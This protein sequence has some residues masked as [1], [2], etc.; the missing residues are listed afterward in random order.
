MRKSTI[1]IGIAA[2]LSTQAFVTTTSA[3]AA[4]KAKPQRASGPTNTQPHFKYPNRNAPTGS[5]VL[6]D[7]SG[8]AENG[9]PAQDFSSTYDAYDAQGADDFVVTDAAGWNVSAFNFQVTF[10]AGGIPTPPPAGIVYNVTV[11]ADG[12]GLPGAAEC[13]YTGVPGVLDGTFTSLS[14]ALTPICSLTQGTHWVS[15][16]AS[17]D[18]PPQSFW[19]NQS[20]TTLGNEGAWQ[21]PGDGFGTGCTAWTSISSCGGSS[22]VGGG[23]PNYLFQVVGAVG[24]GGGDCGAGDLCLVTTVGTDTTPGAC[25][26][27]D[28]IDVS[29]GD[30]LNY[31]YV[32]TNNT[33][34][35]LDYHTLSDNINGTI[36]SLLNQPVPDGGTFQYN[37]IDT[38]SVTE[39]TNSSWTGQDVPPGYAPEVTGGGGGNDRIFCDGF[40]GTACPDLPGGGF[41]DITTT[42]TPL[43][44]GDDSSADVTMPFSFNFYGTTANTLSVSNNGAAVFN[45]PGSAVP[46]TNVSLPATSLA[47][48]TL[49]PLWDD[50]DSESG[51]VFTDTRGTAP[52]RQ[53][54][55]EWFNRVHF[56]GA[57]NT[58]G[59]TFE[60]ILNENGTIQF[61]YLDVDYTA[62]ANASGDPDDCTGGICATIGLQNDETLFNQFSAFEASITDNSGILW[63]P[64]SP[65][66]FTGTDSATVNVGAPEIDVQPPSLSGTVPEGGSNSI[67]FSIDNTGNRDLNWSL[68]E[69]GPADFH[70]PPPG[71]RF[72]MPLGDPALATNVR[73]PA[74]GNRGNRKPGAA[75]HAVFGPGTVP[76]FASDAYNDQFIRFDALNPGTVTTVSS[77]NGTAY[78]LDFIDADFSKAYGIDKFGSTANAFSTIDTATGAVTNIGTSNPSADAGG[79]TGFKYDSTTG[80]AYASGTSCG[81]SSHLYTIDITTGASTLVGE[82]TGM[83]CAITIAISPDGD[84]YGIDIVNDALFAIDK[85]NANATLIGSIGFNANYGQDADFDDATGILYYAAFNADTFTDEIRTV[86]LTSGATTLVGQIGAGFAQIVGLA[87]ET[88]GGPCA[89]PQDLPWLS[90][91]PLAGTTPPAG[92]SPVTASIDG[93]ANVEGDTLAGT[94]CVSSNDP[95]E[96]NVEV[97]I[98]VTVG[99]AGGGGNIVDSGV[100]NVTV[101]ADFTGLYINWLTGATCTSADPSCT[102]LDYN[103]NPWA[104]SGNMSFVWEHAT[105][106]CVA[107]GT[108]CAVL[109]SGAVIGPASTWDNGDALL[110]RAGSTGYI[111]FQFDNGGVTNYGYAKFTTTSPTG[112]PATVNQYWYDNSG[113]AIT[114]P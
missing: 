75:Q 49:A 99:P 24:G 91:S 92:S 56:D 72:A 112:F 79:F 63:T 7:Q 25:A 77:A 62:F 70:F 1:A 43:G 23:N 59:A 18:F 90:L 103:W 48:P 107:A 53:F 45:A 41:I 113:A 83:P 36:F 71:T 37:R 55:V 74:H 3:D 86:D 19:S 31:C 17:F 6:Y 76:A 50:F 40:D 42:G 95:D 12:G 102:P 89:Q 21:N 105:D 111:G 16:E 88:A 61:E 14:V 22:P 60:L 109:A 57:S 96:H 2:A 26:T 13:T 46:F 78:G 98:E 20:G 35:E 67:P 51:D 104:N 32:I 64:T 85:T 80:T 68:E 34:V 8:T 82:L 30:Q 47:G 65:Q 81:S 28:T 54:I 87:I 5:T 97:P 10:S 38:A 39:T 69:A 100:I 93:S 29:V 101:N 73:A 66:S 114:I 94:I 52:N 11:F 110:F 27:T 106:N 44:L 108:S 4:V 58:D 84:M 9:A 33:G 15:L